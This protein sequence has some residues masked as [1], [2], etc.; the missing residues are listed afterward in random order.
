[1]VYGVSESAF[2]M[3]RTVFAI[4]HADNILSNQEI[5]YMVEVLEDVPFSEEQRDILNDDIHNAKSPSA[6]FA[7]VTETRDQVRFFKHAREMVWIDG[8]YAPE[9]QDVMMKLTRK[10]MQDVDLEK[11]IGTIDLELEREEP[12]GVWEEEALSFKQ[13]LLNILGQRKEH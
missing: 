11:L 8:D 12:K 9:E 10:Y 1:M 13:K 3:W 2:Y 5:R 7:F 4:A 6:R